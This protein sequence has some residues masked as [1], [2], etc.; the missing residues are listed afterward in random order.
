MLRDILDG[1]FGSVA[2]HHSAKMGRSVSGIWNLKDD[3]TV[4]EL[5]SRALLSMTQLVFSLLHPLPLVIVQRRAN[6]RLNATILSSIVHQTSVTHYY[7]TIADYISFSTSTSTLYSA[8]PHLH[9]R[10]RPL[11]ARH[12][13][14]L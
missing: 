8:S 2:V 9:P 1:Y 13:L 6:T 11:S 7:S 4:M 12:R 10:P 14:P 5:C 3:K